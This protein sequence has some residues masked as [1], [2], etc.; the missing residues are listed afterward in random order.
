MGG[1]VPEVRRVYRRWCVNSERQQEG[2]GVSETDSRSLM[3]ASAQVRAW[4]LLLDWRVPPAGFEP[5]HTA[6]EAVAL[7]PE[8]RG[9][10]RRGVRG[11]G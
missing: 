2:A 7:S 6:P 5:A 11:D 10:V 1:S 8:L 9:R 3:S 4:F